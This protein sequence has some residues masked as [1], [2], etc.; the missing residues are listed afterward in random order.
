MFLIIFFLCQGCV[1]YPVRFNGYLSPEA[2]K[3]TLL[4]PGQSFFVLEEENPRN[5]LFSAEVRNKVGA[6]LN[7]K[8]YRQGT[9]EDASF[10]VSF[11]YSINPGVVSGLRPVSHPSE[12]GAVNTFTEDGKVTTSYI[13]FPGYT[14]YVPY[15]YTIYTS[16]LQLQALDAQQFRNTREKKVVWLG[17]SFSTSTNPELRE[18]INY[19][20]VNAFEHFGENTKRG[21]SS[22]ISPKDPRIKQ[23]E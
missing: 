16:M 5:P 7:E 23:I 19:L 6:L 20:L 21:I 8:G 12:T 4:A 17:E 14:T 11:T 15:K 1:S 18:T 9:A 2:S 10:Y 13:T 3:S 22:K